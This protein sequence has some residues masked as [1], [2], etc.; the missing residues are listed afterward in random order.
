V[1]V[2]LLVAG[3]GRSFALLAPHHYFNRVLINL[4]NT[5]ASTANRKDFL[6]IVGALVHSPQ[7]GRWGGGAA[8]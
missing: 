4:I 2:N 8:A 7:A 1:P 5:G 3:P 6:A